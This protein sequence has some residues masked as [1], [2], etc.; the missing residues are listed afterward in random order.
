TDEYGSPYAGISA[1]A[2]NINLLD[3]AA[4]ERVISECDDTQSRRAAEYQEFCARNSYWLDSYAAFCAIK[5]LLGEEV[6]QDWPKQYRSWSQELLE[7]PELVQAIELHRKQQ[8]AFDVIWSQTLAEARAKGI[9]IIGDMPMFVSEDSAD[10]WAH[11]ELFALDATGH[12]EL[13]AGAPADAFS[14]DGQLW[15]N[16]TYTW[17]AHKDEGYRWWIERFRR[18]FYLY[19]Y[20]RLDHFIGF[21]SY[22]AIEQGKT[23]AEG[24]FKFGPGLEL[25]DVAYKQLGPLP[26]IA[27]DLGAV[28]PAVRALLSQTGFP[29][30]SVIQFADGDC[31]YSFAPVQESIVYSGTHDTQTLMGFVEARFTGGQ[32][33]DESHQIFDHLIEQVVGTSNAV[34]I[35]PLQDV[36]GLS[37]DARMNIPGKAEGN[38]SWQVKKDILTPQVVQK[39]QRFA[40]LHQSKLDA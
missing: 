10:V 38:W 3:P 22:Y 36:L 4:M 1:F 29:G 19:D 28:T 35:L 20:T 2:G 17:Q 27:E 9:Q 13:Q 33:T 25:F 6:W 31:R 16:P 40:E 26:F 37:D 15:G 11:P 7:R 5:D 18:S 12:T 21:T 23:A 30:M 8:F 34:V 14:Q 39:L 24:S 32:A